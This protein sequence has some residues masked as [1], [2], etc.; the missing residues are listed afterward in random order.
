MEFH[1]MVLIL[2]DEEIAFRKFL[3]SAMQEVIES[4]YIP[5]QILGEITERKQPMEQIYW[6]ELTSVQRNILVA[7]KVMGIELKEECDGEIGASA[8]TPF[9]SDEDGG[10]YCIRCGYRDR[11]GKRS[12]HQEI[13]KNYSTDIGA[14]WL[15]VEYFRGRFDVHIGSA[16]MPSEYQISVID[17]QSRHR[18]ISANAESAPEAICIA[19]L[20]AVGYGVTL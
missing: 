2:N 7:E 12:T 13:A 5:P 18:Y 8:T 17:R 14:A 16:P 20:R 4:M 1:P 19:A 10:W 9:S 15:I 6:N 3:E 11:W